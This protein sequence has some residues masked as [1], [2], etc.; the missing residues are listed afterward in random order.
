MIK[1]NAAQRL[2]TAAKANEAIALKYI[3]SVAGVSPKTGEYPESE[4]GAFGFPLAEGDDVVAIRSL[5][6]HF[7]KARKKISRGIKSFIWALG[8]GRTVVVQYSPDSSNSWI[9]LMDAKAK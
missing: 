1:I 2:V 8:E 9:T 6:S 4:S 5:S 3:K 7:G